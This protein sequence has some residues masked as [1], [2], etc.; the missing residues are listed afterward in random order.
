VEDGGSEAP[1]ASAVGR[2][3]SGGEKCLSLRTLLVAGCLSPYLRKTGVMGSR[4]WSQ[5]RISPAGQITWTGMFILWA[6]A[7]TS[8]VPP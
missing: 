3:G 4:A 8:A 5:S 7:T 1:L 2:H 6:A